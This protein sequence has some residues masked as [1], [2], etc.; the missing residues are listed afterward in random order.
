MNQSPHCSYLLYI[1]KGS[2][3]Q[4]PQYENGTECI[5]CGDYSPPHPKFTHQSYSM[6][7]YCTSIL[8]VEVLVFPTMMLSQDAEL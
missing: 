8:V 3:K 6:T 5:P 7:I 4:S 2:L 1:W